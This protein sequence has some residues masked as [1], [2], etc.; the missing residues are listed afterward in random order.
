MRV[1]D[2]IVV[3]KFVNF[4]LSKEIP[5]NAADLAHFNVVH[6][7]ALLTGG[8]PKDSLFK[9]S[10]LSHVWSAGW[11]ACEEPGNKYLSVMKLHHDLR[12]FNKITLVKQDFE[13]H[14]V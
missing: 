13:T 9:W 3:E 4:F 5:E 1:I 12:L 6:E 7:P 2:R 10:F 14:Q 11:A 8:K